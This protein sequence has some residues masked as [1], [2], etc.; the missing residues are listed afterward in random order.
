MLAGFRVEE[1]AMVTAPAGDTFLL[2]SWG[3]GV[4]VILQVG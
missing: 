2:A 3:D 1:L 4:D